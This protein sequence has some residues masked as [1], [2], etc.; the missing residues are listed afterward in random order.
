MRIAH[1]GLSGSLILLGACT[2]S[3]E[4]AAQTA[5]AGQLVLPPPPASQ[6]VWPTL[7]NP[8][9]PAA[10]VESPWR[11]AS[12]SPASAKTTLAARP[13]LQGTVAPRACCNPVAPVAGMVPASV[14]VTP[15]PSVVVGR[16]L[17]ATSSRP[18]GPIEATAYRLRTFLTTG[19]VRA[20]WAPRPTI[21]EP[22]RVAPA[23]LVPASVTPVMQAPATVAPANVAPSLPVVQP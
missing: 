21:V 3:R 14:A 7:S 8:P 16:P 6:P 2:A 1:A 23:A 11:S 17:I 20:L 5:T 15:A 19:R 22:A 10:G 4:V 18:A 13:I 9:T 12:S